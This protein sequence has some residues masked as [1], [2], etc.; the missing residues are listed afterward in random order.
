MSVEHSIIEIDTDAEI[1]AIIAK[2]NKLPDMIAAPS[3]LKNALNATARKVRRQM[4]KDAEGHYAIKDKGILKDESEGAPKV[5]NASASDLT[6]TVFSK[7]PMQDIMSF[8]TSPNTETG[9]AAAQVLSSGSM[10]PLELGELKAFVV[11]F[12]SGHVAI[13]QRRPPAEY[14]KGR[15]A[16]AEKYGEGA[17]MTKIKKLL[18]PSVPH[19]LGN[20]E[21]RAQA[22]KLTYA[23]LQA[24]IQ[25]RIEKVTS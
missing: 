12:A 24:E 2:L 16:R 22:E 19:M 20:E 5:L 25:K 9:A 11:K 10:K 7:G 18:S 6:A 8:M 21:V 3:I 14:S 1:A 13:V 17:D 15:D 4:V 23:I